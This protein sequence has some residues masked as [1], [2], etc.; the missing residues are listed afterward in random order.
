MV[1]SWR[2]EHAFSTRAQ[3]SAM[4][5]S[6]VLEESN[7]RTIAEIGGLVVLLGVVARVAN[8][9]KFANDPLFL[10][11]GLGFG[12]GGVARFGPTMPGPVVGYRPALRRRWR[13]KI[14]LRM[15]DR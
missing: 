14:W 2:R 5:A 11:V 8:S 9:L 4:Y 6:A 3:L 15:P 13:S 10:V 1:L 12:V 7:M